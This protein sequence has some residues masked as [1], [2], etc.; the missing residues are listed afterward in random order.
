MLTISC[1]Y[2]V[3]AFYCVSFF[4]WYS[5]IFRL[6][7]QSLNKNK[8]TGVPVAAKLDPDHIPVET[9]S[10]LSAVGTQLSIG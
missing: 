5:I 8:I 7:L 10:A 2:P 6:L 1:L 3:I 4:P 9:R